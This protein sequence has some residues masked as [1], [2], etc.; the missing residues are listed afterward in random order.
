[1]SFLQTDKEDSRI[2][3]DITRRHVKGGII[4]RFVGL[5]IKCVTGHTTQAQVDMRRLPATK[6]CPN[7]VRASI[8]VGNRQ[9][10]V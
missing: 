6:V 4:V 2:V 1:M 7:K 10:K 9:G 5:R 8:Y 3:Q